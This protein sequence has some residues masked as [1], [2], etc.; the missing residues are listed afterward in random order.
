MCRITVITSLFN[1]QQYLHGYFEAAALITNKDE[2]EILL[3]HNSP[4]ENELNTINSYLPQ[5]PF[6]KHVV[7]EREGLYAT[8]NRGIKMAKGKYVTT[9]NVDDIRLPNSLKDQADALDQ[10]DNLALSYGDFK[11]VDTYGSTE[12]KSVNE[13]QFD[14]ENRTFYRQHHIGCFPMWRKNIHEKIGYFDEQ[15]TLIADLDFQ[16]RVAKKYSMV[17]ISQQLGY[18][19]EGTAANLSSN[20]SIQDKEHTVLHL[21]YGNFN[22]IFLTHII[23]GLNDL[24][25]FKYKWFGSY[26]AVSKWTIENRLSYISR[27]PMIVFSI[28]KWPRHMARKY[29]KKYLIKKRQEAMLRATSI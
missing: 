15:F 9:W 8:W 11:I 2:V 24:E 1:C 25:V 20:F 4:R 12:G 7:I 23:G 19:L 5:L 22:L 17:K 26:H 28:I 21:R 16:I 10:D 3:I 14:S 6:M 18:Y 29:L 27:L 13:P